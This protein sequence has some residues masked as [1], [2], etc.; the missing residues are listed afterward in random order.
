[1][2]NAAEIARQSEVLEDKSPQDI[3]RWAQG[4]FP[5]GRIGIS[6]AFGAEGCVLL[7]MAAE[8]GAPSWP[9]FYIDTG[10]AF[11]ET[12][13]LVGTFEARYPGLR[14]E[15]VRP[16]QTIDEQAAA[17]GP[18]LYD[19]DPDRCCALRKVEPMDRSL[20]R[21][22]AWISARRRDMASTRAQ[23]PV[24]ELVQKPGPDGARRDLVKVNPLAAWTK[25]KVW[26]YLVSRQVP[27]NPLYDQ[28]YASIGC[29]P[30]TRPVQP[31]ED[32][33]AGRWA[34]KG[35]VECGIHTFMDQKPA[36]EKDGQ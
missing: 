7:D 8:L 25:K 17:H 36:G 32:E 19:R 14:I 6:T 4:H 20:H 35:K 15:V 28:G 22:D 24:L 33:R 31:G 3:L 2:A 30:C 26:D 29:W 21:F 1:M 18:A 11:A 16:L 34:G 27:Y 5:G 12:N 23:I 9:I 13:A 10:F